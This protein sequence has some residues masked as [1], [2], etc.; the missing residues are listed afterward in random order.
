MISPRRSFPR[1]LALDLIH[2]WYGACGHGTQHG[3][4]P[5]A[6]SLSGQYLLIGAQNNILTSTTSSQTVGR[7]GW[8]RGDGTQ[9]LELRQALESVINLT[10]SMRNDCVPVKGLPSEIF[11]R[12]FGLIIFPP[13]PSKGPLS[14]ATGATQTPPYLYLGCE[15]FFPITHSSLRSLS[16][17]SAPRWTKTAEVQSR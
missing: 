10:D 16:V 15:T 4:V 12:I 9:L 17:I 1:L 11:L 6:S 13:P 14:Q 8:P 2:S 5:A 3:I 7:G